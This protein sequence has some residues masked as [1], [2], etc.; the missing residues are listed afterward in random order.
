[1]PVRLLN[2]PI[3]I[4]L[5][6]VNA[7]LIIH[8]LVAIQIVRFSVEVWG[9]ENET[10]ITSFH[11]ILNDAI[12]SLPRLSLGTTVGAMLQKQNYHFNNFILLHNSCFLKT[13]LLFSKLT[14]VKHYAIF[15]TPFPNFPQPSLPSA[16]T[17]F[18]RFITAV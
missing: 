12:E 11:E 18:L 5:C 2:I 8:N 9:T 3:R 10:K 4:V 17:V 13:P 16:I 15:P 7:A 14:K 1:M 6:S